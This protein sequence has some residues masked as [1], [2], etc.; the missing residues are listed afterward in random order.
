MDNTVLLVVTSALKEFSDI[1]KE[2]QD[3][4]PTIYDTQPNVVSRS[5]LVIMEFIDVFA[6]DIILISL[7]VSTVIKEFVDIFSKDI[8]PNSIRDTHFTHL[9]IVSTAFSQKNIRTVKSLCTMEVA[10][11]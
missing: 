6:K 11:M 8:A 5:H 7:K 10:P 4:P 3:K 9:L 2:S 1:P